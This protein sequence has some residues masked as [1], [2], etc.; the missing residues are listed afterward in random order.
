MVAGALMVQFSQDRQS[1]MDLVLR[2]NRRAHFSA[3]ARETLALFEG[4]QARA[5][6]GAGRAAARAT[7][8]R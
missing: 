3:R 5:G 1:A 6:A 7:G 8:I 4:T 2:K